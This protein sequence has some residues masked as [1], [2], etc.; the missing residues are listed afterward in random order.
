[1]LLHPTHT[2]PSLTDRPH[3]VA[4]AAAEAERLQREQAEAARAAK[5]EAAAAK[6]RAIDAQVC[7]G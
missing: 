2:I 6:Q 5:R 4:A 1:M 3:S 7:V